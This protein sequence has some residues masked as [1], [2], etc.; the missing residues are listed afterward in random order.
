MEDSF[1]DALVVFAFSRSQNFASTWIQ[2][3]ININEYWEDLLD[4]FYSTEFINYVCSDCAE[5][6]IQVNQEDFE[7]Y[8]TKS[9]KTW[10]FQLMIKVANKIAY[11]YTNDYEVTEKLVFWDKKNERMKLRYQLRTRIYD[12]DFYFNIL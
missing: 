4:S 12:S 9:K 6:E 7:K 2:Q 3:I 10:R 11:H 8:F 5:L 1:K